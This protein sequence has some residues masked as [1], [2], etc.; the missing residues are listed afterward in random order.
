MN[1]SAILTPRKK[2]DDG[3]LRSFAVLSI[4]TLFL[5]TVFNLATSLAYGGEWKLPIGGEPLKFEL[6]NGMTV[7]LAEDHS[8]PVVAFQ[9][10]VNVGSTDE[11]PELAG[12][13][14]VHEHMLFKG[15]KKRGVGQ[16]SKEVEAAGGDI[17]AWTSFEQTVY[18]LVLASRF[19]DTGLDILSDALRNSTFDADELKREIEV[20]REEIKRGMDQPYRKVSESFFSSVYE[21]HPYGRPVI[22][23]DD[24]VA[25]FTRNQIL[26]FYHKWYV[27]NNMTFVVVG[28][29]DAKKAQAKIRKSFAGFKKGP[30]P[31]VRKPV[32]PDQ[33][34]MRIEILR[35]EVQ[36][37][38]LEWGMPTA[39]LQNEDTP[40][41]DLLSMIL[42]H[43]DSSRL[44]Q[45]IKEQKGLVNGIA[46][47]S[48]TPKDKGLFIVHASLADAKLEQA[49]QQSAY[50]LARLTIEDVSAD[51]LRRCP[52]YHLKRTGS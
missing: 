6:P 33:K 23:Y 47:Y 1:I 2:S 11:T 9:A 36:E 38:F 40:A 25:K 27:P 37:T 16:I 50:E 24:V 5:F 14:H 8:A 7:I 15:T 17:N 13:A 35:D 32:E 39:D 44:N 34:G 18:H 10:W 26:G 22:G 41:L 3:N 30:L 48:F 19:F 20:V 21:K 46:A 29:F 45:N 51:E 42:S 4:C 52:A 28:D 31:R 12:M 49:L 43:G